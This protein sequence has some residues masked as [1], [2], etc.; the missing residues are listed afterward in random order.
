MSAV[1]VDMTC[2]EDLLCTKI[3]L[4]TLACVLCVLLWFRGLNVEVDH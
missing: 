4:K 2:K 3:A 1:L